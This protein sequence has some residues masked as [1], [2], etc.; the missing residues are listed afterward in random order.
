[1]IASIY[2]TMWYSL[3]KTCSIHKYQNNFFFFSM[4]FFSIYILL[5]A[6]APSITLSRSSSLTCD[7]FEMFNLNENHQERLFDD[8]SSDV[9]VAVFMTHFNSYFV[10]LC[11]VHL[12]CSTQTEFKVLNYYLLISFYQVL[13]FFVRSEKTKQQF[14]YWLKISLLSINIY[15]WT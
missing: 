1:M 7:H 6:I 10:R 13:L 4:K 15:S 5:E 14:I 11:G 12:K 8:S 3:F 2:V 9:R